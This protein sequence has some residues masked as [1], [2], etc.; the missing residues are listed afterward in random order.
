MC[1]L[2][3][4]QLLSETFLVIRR[5]QRDMVKNVRWFSCKVPGILV[6]LPEDLS[7]YYL[8]IYTWVFPQVSPPKHCMS[9]LRTQNI[10][11]MV[12]VSLKVRQ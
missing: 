3:Y 7:E 11:L 4:L 2:F 1:V 8:P 6:P 5:I 10:A 12:R 9:L